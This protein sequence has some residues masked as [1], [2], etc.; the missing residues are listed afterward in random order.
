MPEMPAYEME[1]S[2]T[3]WDNKHGEKIVV[4]PGSDALGLIDVLNGA[5]CVLTMQ[6]AAAR[7]LA[8]ALAATADEVESA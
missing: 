1:I 3:I 8:A 7:L 2:R 6:P 5:G 4:K